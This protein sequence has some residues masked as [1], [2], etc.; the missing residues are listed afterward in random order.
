MLPQCNARHIGRGHMAGSIDV[1]QLL[2]GPVVGMELRVGPEA[3]PNMGA[4][5]PPESE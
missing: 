3:F 4:A 5:E 1:I 2:Q